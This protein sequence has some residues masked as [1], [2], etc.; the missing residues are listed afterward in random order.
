MTC[1][2]SSLFAVNRSRTPYSSTS[3]AVFTYVS[4]S[5]FIM[6]RKRF[7][8]SLFILVSIFEKKV[9]LLYRAQPYRTVGKDLKNVILILFFWREEEKNANNEQFS[10]PFSKLVFFHKSRVLSFKKKKTCKISL[11]YCK[12]VIIIRLKTIPKQDM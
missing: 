9:N 3:L 4:K 1:K 8:F 12:I 2:K 7:F 6:F 5:S 11:N 10:S